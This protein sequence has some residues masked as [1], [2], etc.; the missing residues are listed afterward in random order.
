LFGIT[1][2]LAAGLVMERT[3]L[4][5]TDYDVQPGLAVEFQAKRLA[6]AIYAY[7]IGTD[8]SYAV[9]SVGFAP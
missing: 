6:F 7:N 3:K 5:D 4:V 2:Q 1:E 8:D 9:F